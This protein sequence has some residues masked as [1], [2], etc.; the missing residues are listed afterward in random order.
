[1]LDLTK[2]SILI[3]GVL[4][5]TIDVTDRGLQYGD[6][7]FETMLCSDGVIPLLDS[8]LKRLAC[9]C[10]RLNIPVPDVGLIKQEINTYSNN[11]AG[12][13]VVKL[14]VTR[15]SGGK[16]YRP[17]L[18][19][20]P[21][22]ILMMSEYPDDYDYLKKTGI[23]LHLCKTRLARN[24]NLAGI[25]H[26][27]RLEQVLASSERDDSIFHEG[28]MQDSK[29]HIIEGTRMNLFIIWDGSLIT[30][31]LS[32][33]GVAGVFRELVIKQSEELGISVKTCSIDAQ[34]VMSADGVFMT[35]A[36]AGILPVINLGDTTWEIHDMVEQLN[37]NLPF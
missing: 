2:N 6:G 31:E 16:G 35:N 4:K 9:D 23:S 26:L 36:I 29:N 17:K 28:L 20:E 12:K 5:A 37:S 32:H 27:N 19:P 8:H 11:I 15:G 30:P 33:S 21:R 3:N 25:K 13:A 22:R 1:M 10:Q 24:P 7:L 14:I 34:D 18:Q